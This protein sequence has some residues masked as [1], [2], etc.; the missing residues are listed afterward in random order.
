MATIIKMLQ[1][2]SSG[3]VK[4]CLYLTDCQA[5]VWFRKVW[6]AGEDTVI[7][8]IDGWS[9]PAFMR[10]CE[11]HQPECLTQS[12]QSMNDVVLITCEKAIT[13]DS[14]QSA[15]QSPDVVNQSY[16]MS[17][18]VL[19]IKKGR[20]TQH[21]LLCVYITEQKTCKWWKSWVTL[22]VKLLIGNFRI[23]LTARRHGRL[24]I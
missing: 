22:P 12:Q 8:S 1:H 6:T 9:K 2:C 5:E 20:L 16:S 13:G 14:F 15:T 10:T 24:Q 21:T 23:R 3:A 19:Y 4:W 18:H 7:S 11:D 17:W